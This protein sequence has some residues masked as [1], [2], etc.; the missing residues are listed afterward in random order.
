[1]NDLTIKIDRR[2]GYVFGYVVTLIEQ[3]DLIGT[4]LTIKEAIGDLIVQ[5]PEK[6]GISIIDPNAR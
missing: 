1:M 4:G 2:V 3:S 5:C 6:F